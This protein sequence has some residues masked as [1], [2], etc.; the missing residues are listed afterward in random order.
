M[1]I[2]LGL[3]VAPDAVRA[4]AIEMDGGR[5]LAT[6]ARALSTAHPRAAGVEQITEELLSSAAEALAE[7]IA[8]ARGLGPI[9]ALGLAGD[10]RRA[11]L[12]DEAHQPLGEVSLEGGTPAPAPARARRVLTR[13]DYVG[14]WLTGELATDASSLAALGG[15]PAS[16]ATHLPDRLS[17]LGVREEWLPSVAP[18]PSIL[19][20]VTSAAAAATSLA[21]GTPVVVGG[22][23]AAL[24]LLGSGA[25][26]KGGAV[27]S[28]DGGGLVAATF[29]DAG[30]DLG[31][32]VQRIPH[33][34]AARFCVHAELRDSLAMLEWYEQVLC[35]GERLA[36]EL[37]REDLSNIV[38]EAASTSRPGAGG[39]LFVPPDH[40]AGL[41]PHASKAEISRA[42]IE[43]ITIDAV[44]ALRTIE[45]A[46]AGRHAKGT[47]G[48]SPQGAGAILRVAGRVARSAFWRQLVADVAGR[49]VSAT[50]L[51]GAACGAALVA[52]VA[53]G[54]YASVDEA[55]DAMVFPTARAAPDPATSARYADLVAAVEE[56][57]HRLLPSRPLLARLG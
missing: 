26:R 41:G 43:G 15:A 52:T 54:A 28:V 4:V 14:L 21:G 39:V 16:G 22:A 33:V 48:S 56:L 3:E 20:R 13:K 37:R 44:R 47:N 7:V 18:S 9:A 10:P 45:A 29:D 57:S 24:A 51:E 1:S 11:V 6:T 2:V 46:G 42:F 49:H 40:L 19:G 12:V 36:A 5:L 23:T 17:A 30:V 38:L 53:S 55:A 31:V 50:S 35:D 8:A 25:H 32:G 34:V 27:L